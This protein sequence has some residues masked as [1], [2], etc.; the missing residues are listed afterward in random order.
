[1][2]EMAVQRLTHHEVWNLMLE[3]GAANPDSFGRLLLPLLDGSDLL[4]HYMTTPFAARTI[5]SLSRTLSPAEHS[6]L[7]RAILRA[8]DP[9]D[10]NGDRPQQLVD[11]LLGQLDPNCIQDAIARGRLTELVDQNGPPPPPQPPTSGGGFLPFGVRER[12]SQSGAIYD[13]NGALVEAMERLRIDVMGTT[14]GATDDQH[15]ARGRL[16]ES[17]PA[18]YSILIPE[19]SSLDRV[20]FDEAL[21]LMVNGAERL[22]S[23]PEILPGTDL[24]EMVL[25]ILRAGLSSI[26]NAGGNS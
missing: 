8:R 3:A 10:P 26:E 7:E 2:I 6:D 16:R 18:L 9:L 21:T 24:G 11:T 25:G 23:D 13:T 17:L 4:G 20:V 12:L 19:S 1:M 22:A 14:S 5:A 15:G